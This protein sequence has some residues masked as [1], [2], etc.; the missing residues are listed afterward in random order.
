MKSFFFLSFFLLFVHLL[1]VDT[2]TLNMAKNSTRKLLRN[3]SRPFRSNQGTHIYGTRILRPPLIPS[4]LRT[5][6]QSWTPGYTYADVRAEDS[7]K[8]GGYN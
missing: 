6:W 1:T 2:G 7:R 4:P 3:G 8:D 5:L